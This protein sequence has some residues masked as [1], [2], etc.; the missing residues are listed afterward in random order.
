MEHLF[1][2]KDH[3][4]FIGLTC[5]MAIA[6]CIQ[7]AE[8]SA[9]ILSG[10][11]FFCWYLQSHETEVDI[12]AITNHAIYA[13]ES[14][15]FPSFIKGEFGDYEWLGKARSHRVLHIH[16]PVHQNLAHIRF[17]RKFLY[18]HFGVWVFVHNF[19]VVPDS[20]M[21][22]SSCKEIVHSSELY[23]R[24]K[25]VEVKSQAIDRDVIYE[26]M[27]HYIPKEYNELMSKFQNGSL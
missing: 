25:T 27:R 11:K 21:I 23:R 14:K 10:Q 8:P 17:I 26:E 12:I 15:D 2:D 7:N 4:K 20:C 9:L 16:N 18:E 1:M 6:K 24:I 5:E 19:I 3:L 13:I 22:R